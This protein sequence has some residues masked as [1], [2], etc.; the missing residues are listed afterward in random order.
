MPKKFLNSIWCTLIISIAIAIIVFFLT[1]RI[2]GE[3][4]PVIIS[5]CVSIIIFLLTQK[6]IM[7]KEEGKQKKMEDERISHEFNI[8]PTYKYVDDQDDK[9]MEALK[10]HSDESAETNKQMVKL[11]ESVDGNV[12]ILLGKLQ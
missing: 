3:Q 8:R 1:Q 7:E 2:F 9:I 12:K 4:E 11:I 5:V 10:R 6:L